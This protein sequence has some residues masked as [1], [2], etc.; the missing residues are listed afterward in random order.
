MA[1]GS[2]LDP[3]V[4]NVDSLGYGD[5]TPLYLSVYIMPTNYF[6]TSSQWVTVT[7][8]NVV[9]EA[10]CTPGESCG[11]EWF[12]CL[13]QVDV[14]DEVLSAFGGSLTVTVS[15]EGISSGPCDY[16]GY[17]LYTHMYLSGVLPSG[18]PT[19]EPT[20]QPSLQPSA[21]PS[22]QPS[23]MPSGQPTCQPSGE[24]SSEPSNPSGEPSSEPSVQ[25]SSDPSGQPSS[26]P[27]SE[28]SR[29]PSCSPSV[30][31]SSLPS[32]Q[33]SR[34]PT[35]RPS[36]SPSTSPSGEPSCRPTGQP[37]SSPSSPSS[38]PSGQ[39]SSQPTSVLDSEFDFDERFVECYQKCESF[40]TEWSLSSFC[41]I[42]RNQSCDQN[43]VEGY[44]CRPD[45]LKS[46]PDVFCDSFSTLVYACDHV[47][48]EILYENK[49]TT[50]DICLES[51]T[52]GSTTLTQFSFEIELELKG[53]DPAAME[54]DV[55]AQNAVK[56]AMSLTMSGIPQS[57]L[58]FIRSIAATGQPS[59]APTLKPSYVPTLGVALS[60][61]G[62]RRGLAVSVGSSELGVVVVVE[63]TSSL[64]ELGYSSVESDIAVASLT[65]QVAASVTSGKMRKNLVLSGSK[66]RTATLTSVLVSPYVYKSGVVK[67]IPLV[68]IAPT[69]T[70]TIAPP[71][72]FS[73]F[74]LESMELLIVSI[75]IVVLVFVIVLFVCWR[76]HR[77][78]HESR[79]AHTL[80]AFHFGDDFIDDSDSDNDNPF[81]KVEED[82]CCVDEEAHDDSSDTSDEEI[83]IVIKDIQPH[84]EKDMSIANAC[85]LFSDTPIYSGQLVAPNFPRPTYYSK[86]ISGTTASSTINR[87]S[88]PL[89]SSEFPT[90]ETLRNPPVGSTKYLSNQSR[91][92]R[93]QFD[94]EEII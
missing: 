62:M 56:R 68:T 42:Y 93:P 51:V 29:Q 89:P 12:P 18:Q 26:V 32:S 22:N 92:Q 87:K 52:D 7:V 48:S 25:P 58:S 27:S 64:E 60:A 5:D 55:S 50:E 45:C 74:G 39:P 63:V 11:T 41:D 33:P 57:R 31:P 65:T 88:T 82:A 90:F 94:E 49:S 43:S 9:L 16:E 19:M 38:Q 8:N 47:Y 86:H 10:K 67:V 71:V 84:S 14:N 20:S 69:L 80:D 81:G 28:P 76:R 66:L 59:G 78:L 54:V 1:G 30:Q 40:N 46:C 21:E 36:A 72:P 13:S 17:P 24:P 34:Q 2:D 79:K 70:P 53:V 23:C 15:S 85:P 61:E 91:R 4:W 83:V 77:S 44:S 6:Y 73:I 35:S 75:A 3:V 37:T